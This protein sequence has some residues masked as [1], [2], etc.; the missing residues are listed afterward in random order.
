MQELAIN[1]SGR[2][3]FRF[4]LILRFSCFI[5]LSHLSL[6]SFFC[7]FFFL[8]FFSLSFF[9]CFRSRVFLSSLIFCL[10][11]RLCSFFRFFLLF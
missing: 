3:R 9:F 8:G 5:Y 2:V 6:F 10:V 11:A 4:F 7:V 1:L